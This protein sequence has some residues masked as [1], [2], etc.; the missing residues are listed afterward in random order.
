VWVKANGV[1]EI[2]TVEL[3][4]LDKRYVYISKGLSAEDQVVTTNLASVIEGASLRL[5]SEEVA[6]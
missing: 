1:L 6:E 2:R 4:F 3:A 5:A